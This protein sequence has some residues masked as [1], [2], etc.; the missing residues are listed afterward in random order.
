MQTYDL[1]QFVDLAPLARELDKQELRDAGIFIDEKELCYYRDCPWIVGIVG[2]EGTQF[3]GFATLNLGESYW[4][5]IKWNE[6]YL[7]P[8]F[9]RSKIGKQ[10]YDAV[11]QV[12]GNRRLEAQVKGGNSA[13]GVL[14]HL[15]WKKEAELENYDGKGTS[16]I[17]LS[18]RRGVEEIING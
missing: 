7:F 6:F 3:A 13:V 18:Y 17:Q 11:L 12:S 9:R 2:M 1:R 10:F 8:R 15:G 4:G 16:Y 5:R 14:S